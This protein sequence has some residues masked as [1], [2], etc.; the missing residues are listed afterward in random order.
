VKIAL[1]T[2]DFPPD[3]IGGVSA[4]TKD[5]ATAL[6]RAGHTVTVYAKYTGDTRT[7]DTALPF[8]VQ[9]VRGR[10]WARWGGWWM[11]WA[12]LGKMNHYDHVI[13]ATWPL[14]AHLPAIPRL[15]V[16][17]HGSEITCLEDAPPSLKALAQT[18]Y[19]WFPVSKFLAS[20]LERLVPACQR[21]TPLPMPLET[22]AG[23]APERGEHLVCV[24]RDSERKGIDRAINIAAATGRPIT[25]IGRST[26]PPN[27]MAHGEIS[28]AETMALIRSARALILT[29]RTNSAGLGAE[30]LG[31]CMLE[32]ASVGVPSIGCDTGGVREALGPGLLLVDPDQ[33]DGGVIN[34]W[35]DDEAQGMRAQAWLKT[36]H[37][38][39]LAVSTLM[40]GLL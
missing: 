14:A 23:I 3:F 26:Q 27:G 6:H 25:L 32:A 37:G 11:R 38:P 12:L 31:L 15:A 36:H 1:L 28:R 24:A 5:M 17:V 33:P 34:A 35:L 9:R 18:A 7:H 2:L 21:V 19:A 16:A 39:D 4:W 30:G 40:R 29:P 13:C 22:D 20:E 10:S 8:T